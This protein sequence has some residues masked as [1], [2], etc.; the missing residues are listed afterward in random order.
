MGEV[1]GTSKVAKAVL[2]ACCITLGAGYPRLWNLRG[3]RGGHI[4]ATGGTKVGSGLQA[5]GFGASRD[6]VD[7]CGDFVIH[8][9]RI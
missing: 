9:G 5:A 4:Y 2:G 8:I 3:R 6:A 1:V 7:L